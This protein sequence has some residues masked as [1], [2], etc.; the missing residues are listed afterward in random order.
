MPKVYGFTGYG[1][2]DVQDFWD[3]PKPD[4]GPGELLIAVRAAGVNPVDWKIRQGYLK[5]YMP[6][7]LPAVLGREAAGVVEAIGKDVEGFAVGDEVLGTTAPNSGGYAEYTLLTADA[8]TRK[9]AQVS[10]V[11]AAALPVAAATAFDA[12]QQLALAPGSTLFIN[13]I[14]G[15]VGVAAAQIARDAGLSVIGTGGD[16]KRDLVESL[17]A[18]FIDYRTDVVGAVLQILPDGVDAVLDLVGG[19]SLRE[20]AELVKNRTKVLSAGDQQTVEEV[21]GSPVQRVGTGAVLAQV[22][23]LVADGK[24]N[25]HAVD[26]RPLD[27]AGEAL[28]A[29]ESGHSRGK[30]VIEIR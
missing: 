3:Q 22:A 23:Q 21:G 19:N 2:T 1:G 27:E 14:G 20:V 29:V 15:G 13:G 6:L 5:D 26:V 28:Q 17:G 10:F 30:V 12:I 9:P 25:P 8:A 7:D 11:D 4:P 16:G 24:L 18:T